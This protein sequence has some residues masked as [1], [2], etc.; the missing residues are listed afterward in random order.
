MGRPTSF[1]DSKLARWGGRILEF[2]AVQGAV[3]LLNAVS[4]LLIVR[5]LSKPDYVLFTVAN[6]MQVTCNQ[7]ADLGVGIGLRS[8]GAARAGNRSEWGQLL[9]T[10]L[11]LR[12]YFATAAIVL[13]LP[14]MWWLLAKNDANWSVILGLCGA[15]LLGLFPL[16]EFP[17]WLTCLLLHEEFRRVQWAELS[18]ALLRVTV[19]AIAASFYLRPILAVLVGA[20]GL[21][22]QVSL[23]RRWA[24]PKIDLQAA[25]SEEDRKILW[26]LSLKA[27]PNSLFYCFQGQA[28]ILILTLV[29]NKTGLADVTALGRIAVLFSVMSTAFGQIAAPRFAKV[30]DD[31]RRRRVYVMLIGSV[32]AVLACALLF[33]KFFPSAFLWL[34]GSKYHGLQEECFLL[35]VGTCASQLAGGLWILNSSKAWIDIYS[36]SLI[37]TV[38]IAQAAAA[39][40]LDLH[41]LHHVLYFSIIT[42]VAPLPSLIIDG[43]NGLKVGTRFNKNLESGLG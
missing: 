30:V 1:L 16:V 18:V 26:K 9:N 19:I 17:A 31:H 38:L 2:G 11:D 35:M 39:W 43:Y 23:L 15:M 40:Y 28:T 25:P 36:W 29:G 7:L 27:L 21:W 37:P 24:M 12:R 5:T 42:A 34:L 10:A 13:C 14:I 4:G 32:F 41:N 22:L 8:L 33:V 20:A 3:Q 6:A